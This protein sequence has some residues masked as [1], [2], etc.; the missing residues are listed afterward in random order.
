MQH[1]AVA[2]GGAWNSHV[3]PN[4]VYLICPHG[5]LGNEDYPVLLT[6]TL[7]RAV[8]TVAGNLLADVAL[9]VADP[10]IRLA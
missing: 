2:A 1:C 6:Y 7:I 9:T 4:R 5:D 10:R 8:L 3:G